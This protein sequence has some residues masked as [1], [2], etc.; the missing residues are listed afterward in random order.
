VNLVPG[1]LVAFGVSM[2]A[3]ID[4]RDLSLLKGADYLGIA[5]MAV[6]LG[7]LEYVLEEGARWNWLDDPTIR[8]CAVISACAG[9]VFI[10]RCLSVDNPI[11]DLRALANRNFTIGCILSFLTGVG[12]F[13]SIYL[14]PLFLGYVRGYDAW[15]T[16]VAM[17]PTGIAALVGVPVYVIFARKTDLRWL[18]MFGMAMF[19]LSMWDF[20]FITHDWGNQQL[21]WP[22]LIRGFPQV[23]A[24]APAVTLGLGSLPPERLKYASGLFNMMRNLGGAVGIAIVGA[25]LNNRTNEHFTDIASRLTAA[26]Q[27]MQKMLGTLQA[28]LGPTLGSAQAGAAASL[29]ELH[30]IAFREAQ[31]MAYGDALTIIMIGFMFATLIVPLMRKVVPPPPPDSSKPA[32]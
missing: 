15:Q 10:A 25:I 5:L 24:I 26:N 9:S 12:A 32:N 7:T 30:D 4:R 3:D 6:F 18:M 14:T 29:R 16:G 11:V 27:P 22:Q 20:R 28:Q 17:V 19:G 31:T 8:R 21:L 1:L 2:S 13:S 23:F